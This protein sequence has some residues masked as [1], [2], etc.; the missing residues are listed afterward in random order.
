M[1]IFGYLGTRKFE[2]IYTIAELNAPPLL[3]SSAPGWIVDLAAFCCSKGLKFILIIVH[4]SIVKSRDWDCHCHCHCHHHEGE[5][6][7]IN[8]NIEAGYM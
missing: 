2:I 3:L 6:K 5:E 7:E 1:G 4:L 8:R